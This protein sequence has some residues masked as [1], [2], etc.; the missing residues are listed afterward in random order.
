MDNKKTLIMCGRIVL[1]NS[2]S[3]CLVLLL[4]LFIQQLDWLTSA[5]SGSETGKLGYCCYIQKGILV[6]GKN[7]CVPS[8]IRPWGG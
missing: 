6:E 8:F 2:C 4:L 1:V 5:S 7:G 3:I